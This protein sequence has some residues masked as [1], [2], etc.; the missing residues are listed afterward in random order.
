MQFRAA[1][2][3]APLFIPLLALATL[4]A[5]EPTGAPPNQGN[6]APPQA[7]APPRKDALDPQRG[8]VSRTE[9][10]AP[11]YTLFA[12][13][14]STFTYLVDLDG[15]LVHQWDCGATP[16]NS[17]YLLEDG[18]LL[19]TVKVNDNG[20]FR[21]GGSG[22]RVQRFS[23]DG[24]LLW[25]WS[26]S[27][28]EHLHHHD[29]EPL[30]NGNILLI[31]WESKSREEALAAGRDEERLGESL[32][33]D[34]VVEVKPKG[35][36]GA[37]VV[38]SWHMWDHLIQDRNSELANFGVVGDHPER[39]DI[40]GDRDPEEHTDEMRRKLIALGYLQAAPEGEDEGAEG[41]GRGP[42]SDWCH[43][44][45]IHYDA[46]GDRILLSVRSMNEIWIID[47]STTTEEAAGSVG[48][49]WGRGGDLLYRWGNPWTYQRG[50]RDD[51][52]LFLQHD[53]RWIPGGS[54]GAGH[55][56][57]FNNGRE[58]PG[59][60]YSSV[61]EI[62]L[63]QDESGAYVLEEDAPFGPHEL[64]WKY[65]APEP[66][67]FYSSHISGAERLSNG[68]TLICD[69]E[70]GRF[71]EVTPGGEIAWDYLN[72]FVPP[73][74]GERGGRRGPGRRGPGGR[75]SGRPGGEGPGGERP[76]GGPGGDGPPEGGPPGGG[77]PADRLPPGE[78]PE[79]NAP[80]DRAPQGERP[81]GRPDGPP[82]GGPQGRNGGGPGGSHGVFRATRIAP[83]YPGLSRLSR[84]ETSE[85]R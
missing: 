36:D 80:Q 53:A 64:T 17:V 79:G 29:I 14:Q 71:F 59:G 55:V 68:N 27:S 22:G 78:L 1:R 75:G 9:A 81:Q 4:A 3:T 10:A 40:N 73:G 52:K 20:V 21:G 26:L 58:R 13:L 25:D 24:E 32:W 46:E 7:D 84:A 65:V 48:G 72:P 38:W 50:V 33:P 30:P 45:G 31:A 43:T 66:A 34:Y 62:T 60:E 85:D 23:W 47:H 54:P 76:Q 57:I 49:R 82:G 44:N 18:S 67:S 77:P 5:Q 19:H 12:P 16:G 37:D 39:I 15:E 56:T 41:D 51:R 11:G 8:L 74:G 28:D 63:P 83:D 6:P 70:A 2:F 35:K 69:G 42:S 61:I